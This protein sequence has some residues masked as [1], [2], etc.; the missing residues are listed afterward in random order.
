MV[1]VCLVRVFIVSLTMSGRATVS[2][3]VIVLLAHLCQGY[4]TQIRVRLTYGLKGE[5][6]EVA[7]IEAPG[8]LIIGDP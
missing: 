1:S 7:T 3:A 8:N 6:D 2:E 4:V 5:T